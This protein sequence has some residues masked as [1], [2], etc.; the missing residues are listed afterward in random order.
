MSAVTST[1]DEVLTPTVRRF[2]RRSLF[3]VAL[4]TI[5]VIIAFV[6]L[7]FTGAVTAS[8]DP[9]DPANAA[10]EGAKA[11]AEVLKHEGVEVVT[12]TT[13]TDTDDAIDDADSTTLVVNDSGSLLTESQWR[14][15]AGLAETIV[16]IDPGY[17][18]LT[19]L[20]PEVYQSGYVDDRVLRAR[21]T[22]DAAEAA[23]AISGEGVGFRTTGQTLATC[24]PSGD[25]TYSLVQVEVGDALVSILGATDALSNG[26]IVEN[27]NAALGLHLLGSQP[28]LVWYTPG[29]GDVDDAP[30]TAAELSPKWVVPV[31]L[32]LV[33]VFITAALWRGRRFGPI[34]VETL[35]VTVRANETM[36]GRAR[37]YQH[38]STRLHAIDSLR[39]GT[40]NRCA[41]M[42]GLP[43]VATVDEV[44]TGV[45]SITSRPEPE[46]RRLLVDDVPRSDRELVAL[47]DQLLTL[48]ALV[49]SRLRPE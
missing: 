29:I 27:G 44:I 40:V 18:A 38:S 36:L 33:L 43:A 49:S 31:A 3:W 11:L 20:A 23:E 39:I 15:V 7:L 35:P 37:L 30:L 10:P 26:R 45:A 41:A 6:G 25:G 1:D 14:E 46:I 17:A 2:L 4:A 13:L 47:S 32:T 24:F 42:L 16:L 28:T 21:C 22:V 9:L 34:I 8:E 5:L 19:E 48:E 12:T